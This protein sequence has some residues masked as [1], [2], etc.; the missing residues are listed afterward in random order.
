[1]MG[2]STQAGI[3]G[4]EPAHV[5][6]KTISVPVSPNP[7]IYSTISQIN[8]SPVTGCLPAVFLLLFLKYSLRQLAFS[9]SPHH[10][11]ASFIFANILPLLR[12]LILLIRLFK[13]FFIACCEFSLSVTHSKLSLL[14]FVLLMQ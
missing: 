1:M 3:A 12:H 5:W 7:T 6:V 9:L 2:F 14:L 8:G 10:I 4:V 11:H 13:L